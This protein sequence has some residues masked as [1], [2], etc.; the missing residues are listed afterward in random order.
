MSDDFIHQFD[1]PKPPRPEF[2]AALYH[3]ITQPMKTTS[4]TYFIQTTALTFAVVAMVAAVLFVLPST[5]AF[6][7]S[8]IQQFTKGSVTIQTTNDANVASQLAGFSVLAPSYLPNGFTANNQRGAWTVSHGTDGVMADISYH[9]Q[10][11]NAD[12]VIVEQRGGTNTAM[13]SADIQVVTVRGQPATWMPNGGRKSILTWNE[14]NIRYE[15]IS[16]LLTE[17]EVLKVAASL[18]K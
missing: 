4:R 17:D 1:A 10:A 15:I 5:R 13:N 12:F 2:T 11:T 9:N 16:N 6:A 18:G 7:D 8:I 3:R 14:N